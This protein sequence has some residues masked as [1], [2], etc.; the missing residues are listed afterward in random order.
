LHCLTAQKSFSTKR[1]PAGSRGGLGNSESL[2]DLRV[3][4]SRGMRVMMTVM[5]TGGEH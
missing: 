5:M 3:S 4:P 2:V 1:K